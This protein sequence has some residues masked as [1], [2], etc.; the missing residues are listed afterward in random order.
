MPALSK[1]AFSF[2]EYPLK[3]DI[4]ELAMSIEHELG[5]NSTTNEHKR[6]KQLRSLISKF[7]EFKAKLEGQ[8]ERYRF[9]FFARGEDLDEST[10]ISFTGQF[11]FGMSVQSTVSPALLKVPGDDSPVLVVQKARVLTTQIV[12]PIDPQIMNAD[13]SNV[14]TLAQCPCY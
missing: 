5:H 6:Q 13:E 12:Q 9:I 8:N 2:Y 14:K 10:M 7:V 1:A 11:A 3:H 4:E